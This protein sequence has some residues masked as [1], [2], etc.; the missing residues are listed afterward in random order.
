MRI[1]DQIGPGHAVMMANL[2]AV[3]QEAKAAL[4]F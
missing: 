1:T 3:Y 4:T 2:G